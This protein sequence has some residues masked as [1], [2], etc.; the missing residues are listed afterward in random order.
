MLDGTAARR[1]LHELDQAQAGELADVIADV[2]ERGAELVCDLAGARNAVVEHPE[3]VDAQ[4]M[5]IRL[6]DL[7]IGDVDGNSQGP[8]GTVK[9][10]TP[11]W[12]LYLET[13]TGGKLR[14]AVVDGR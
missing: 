5:R 11:L 9:A 13:W 1:R 2:G 3:D 8:D 7:G 12:G 4:W 14:T 10:P 6:R